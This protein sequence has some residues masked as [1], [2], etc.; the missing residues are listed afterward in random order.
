MAAA[1]LSIN[2]LLA[3][4]NLLPIPPLDGGR[5][6]T[7]LLPQHLTGMLRAV[8]GVGYVLVLL[9]VMNTS[10]MSRLVDPVMRFFLYFI[11]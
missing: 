11:R 10:I 8:E 4:F 6:L 5:V 3:V 7:A 9:V 1:S 2:C